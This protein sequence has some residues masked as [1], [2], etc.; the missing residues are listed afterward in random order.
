MSSDVP[1]LHARNL[2]KQFGHLSA[3]RPLSVDVEKGASLGIFG[4]NG[5]GKTT[6]LRIAATLIRS[7]RGEMSLFGTP[8]REA[9][10]RIRS[11]LGFVS[12]ESF[13][14]P[15][16]TVLENLL[17][18][19]RLYGLS[20]TEARARETV[21]RLDLAPKATTP[22]RALSRG[23]KQRLSLGRAF[24]HR[25][26]LLLLD[27]PFTGLDERASEIL[28]GLL[29]EFRRGGGT[30]VMATHDLERGWKHARR[31]IVLERGTIAV[32]SSVDAVSYDEFRTR[33]REI[34][35]H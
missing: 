30:T 26:E 11:R 20:G 9:D 4:R 8:I 35:S 32:D 24:L 3:L 31:F 17:F 19:G 34:L 15:D 28:D 16:L 13:L 29:D 5:A 18:Y 33:Y 10:G 21:E 1:V 27:E 22:V 7:F 23:M 6:F 2:S 14:Y 12:H 25:P